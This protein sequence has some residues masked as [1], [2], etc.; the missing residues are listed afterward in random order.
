MLC[1]IR[2]AQ[3]FVLNKCTIHRMH[4]YKTQTLFHPPPYL[5]LWCCRLRNPVAGRPD[6]S[7]W[8]AWACHRRAAP[9]VPRT[10][11]GLVPERYRS[12]LCFPPSERTTFSLVIAHACDRTSLAMSSLMCGLILVLD[13]VPLNRN[14]IEEMNRDNVKIHSTKKFPRT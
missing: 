13:V 14:V 4:R 11:S 5:S 7:G 12:A 1:G 6:Q 3:L 10:T 8:W 9:L 2:N